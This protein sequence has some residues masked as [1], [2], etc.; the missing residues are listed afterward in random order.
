[1][2]IKEFTMP[3]SWEV[4]FNNKEVSD[5]DEATAWM[6]NEWLKNCEEKFWKWDNDEQKKIWDKAK[7]DTIRK[8]PVE[9]S[10]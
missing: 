5:P 10:R 6:I 3:C 7:E 1:M 8:F 9:R 2:T 4:Q